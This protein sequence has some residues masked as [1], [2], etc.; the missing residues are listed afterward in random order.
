MEG[1]G[2]LHNH[3]A[4]HLE[5]L[6]TFALPNYNGVDSEGASSAASRGGSQS[7]SSGSRNMSNL[8]LPSDSTDEP[9]EDVFLENQ[10]ELA[11]GESQAARIILKR[12]LEWL[13]LPP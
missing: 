3:I 13:P 10:S 9:R 1:L 6:A 5:R 2:D 11:L 4:N 7:E 12:F 8:S